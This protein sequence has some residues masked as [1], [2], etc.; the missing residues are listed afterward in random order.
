MEKLVTE[1]TSRKALRVIGPALGRAS[2]I[3]VFVGA[4][5][6]A[7]LYSMHALNNE[8]FTISTMFVFM[9]TLVARLCVACIL[10]ARDCKHLALTSLQIQLRVVCGIAAI[11]YCA[12]L[13]N[14]L[15]DA[16]S[17]GARGIFT[18]AIFATIVISS[19]GFGL[20]DDND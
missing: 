4:L 20:F 13:A 15:P 1:T 5:T 11:M 18:M 3:F 7:F 6:F 2:A 8:Y 10:P 17:V 9:V 12:L 16:I 14:L 19:V